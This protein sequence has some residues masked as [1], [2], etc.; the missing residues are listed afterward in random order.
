MDQGGIVQVLET[1]AQ[2]LGNPFVQ[3]QKHFLF[4]KM[5]GIKIGTPFGRDALLDRPWVIVRQLAA[6]LKRHT[7]WFY[8]TK[9]NTG[10]VAHV[11]FDLHL[12]KHVTLPQH[13]APRNYTGMDPR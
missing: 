1:M 10:I 2:F 12:L 3:K 6:K 9:V 7:C 11:N 4:T 5:E 13:A 8:P